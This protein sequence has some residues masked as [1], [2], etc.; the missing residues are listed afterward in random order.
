MSDKHPGRPLG[1]GLGG[2]TRAFSPTELDQFLQ[3]AKR[4]G[5]REDLMMSLTYYFGL[6]VA[7]L[8]EIRRADINAASRS[9]VIR[10]KKHGLT[11]DYPLPERLWKKYT[12]YLRER[13]EDANP[14]L[15][16]HRVYSETEHLTREGAMSAFERI[17]QASGVQGSHSIH[18]LRHTCA[19]E[20]ARRGD[21][22]YQIASWMR[23]RSLSSSMR[24]IDHR[25][26]QAHAATMAQRAS[27]IFR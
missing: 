3:A 1:T 2:R 12:A 16:R 24:Y 13:G 15:F 26:D 23:H 20:M 10:A 21:S 22:L 6:R 17:L 19:Q 4:T 5:K 11:K 27:E 7:E 9:I 8:V 25:N 14:W 18:D